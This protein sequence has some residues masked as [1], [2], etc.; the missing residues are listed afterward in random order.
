MVFFKLKEILYV[1]HKTPQD[2]E[3]ISVSYFIATSYYSN[4]R[5]NDFPLPVFMQNMFGIFSISFTPSL[6]CK[7]KCLFAFF[8]KVSKIIASR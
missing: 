7:F 1:R 4:E 6:I 8:V 2:I 5:S 3:T